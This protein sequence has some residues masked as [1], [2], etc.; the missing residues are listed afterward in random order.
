MHSSILFQAPA[1]IL[2]I[3]RLLY[4]ISVFILGNG[5]LF[6]AKQKIAYAESKNVPGAS[7]LVPLSGLLIVLGTI[8]VAIGWFAQ[9]GALMLIVFLIP[10]SFMMHDYWNLEDPQQK[11]N[12][13]IHFWKNIA[14]LGGALIILYFGAGPISIQ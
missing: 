2:L 13:K 10:T 7:F 8:S 5:N 6:Q 14:L 1:W 9:V 11:M 12:Q 3:G 4:A